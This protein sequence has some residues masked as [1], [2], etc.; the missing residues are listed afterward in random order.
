MFKQGSKVWIDGRLYSLKSTNEDGTML[1]SDNDWVD[2]TLGRIVVGQLTEGQTVVRRFSSALGEQLYIEEGSHVAG[3][4][5]AIMH[6]S[7]RVTAVVE[8]RR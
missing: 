1:V 8:R 4:Y 6:D 2:R 3:P 5:R 7:K